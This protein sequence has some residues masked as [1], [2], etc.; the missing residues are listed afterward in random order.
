MITCLRSKKSTSSRSRLFS[1]SIFPN[2]ILEREWKELLFFF[3]PLSFP[4]GLSR[5]YVSRIHSEIHDRL[6]FPS[7]I[8]AIFGIESGTE[9]GE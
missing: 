2:A 9:T 8:D 7:S 1:Y 5:S 6:R 4:L 3:L